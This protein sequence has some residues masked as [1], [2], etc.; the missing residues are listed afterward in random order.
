MQFLVAPARKAAGSAARA[1]GNGCRHGGH[2][3]EQ[4]QPAAH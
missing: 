1:A 2:Q 3:Q 4:Q